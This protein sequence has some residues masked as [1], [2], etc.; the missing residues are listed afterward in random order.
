M[1]LEAALTQAVAEGK[2]LQASLDNINALLGASSNP[3]YRQ[4][5]EELAN[6]GQW[7]ELNDRFF[8]ALKFGTGGLRGRTIGNIVTS[9]E[10][11]GEPE[12]MRPAN[13]CVGTNAMNFFNV[14]RA[15]RGLVQY[16]IDYRK[17]DGVEGK[18]S[19]VFAHDTRHFSKDFAHFAAKI[20][21]DLGVNVYLFESCR[22]TPE[23]SYAVRILRADAGVMITASHNPAHDNGYKVNFN[24]GAGIVEP[25]ATGII[26]QVNAIASETYEALPEAEQGKLTILG[27]DMDEEYLT[28]VQTLMLKPELLEK[29]KG[30]KIVYTALHGTGGV[31]VPKILGKLGFDYVTVP[32]QDIQ[33]GRFPTV[34]SP[35]PENAPTLKMAADLADQVGADAI[36]GTDPDCD[37]MG[38]GVR[39]KEGKLILLTGNQIGSLMAWYRTKTMFELGWLTEANKSHAVLLKTYVTSPMQDTI[40]AKFG[41]NCVNTL[42]GFKW[43]SSKLAKYEAQLGL[44]DKYRDL[45]EAGTRAIRLEKSRFLVFGGEESYGYMGSDF[46][47]DKD[48]NGA[49]VMFAELAAYAAS[50][51]QTVADLLDQVYAEVG[52]FLE[53]NKSKT[54]E[55]AEGAAKIAKLADSYGTNPPTVIDGVQV[56]SVR[57]FRKDV[58]HDEEGERVPAEKMLFVDLAD[59]RSFAV[60]PSGTEPKIKYYMFGRSVPAAGAKFSADELAAAK[61]KAAQALKDLWA[62]LDKDIDARLA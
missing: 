26:K 61:D 40:A 10:R 22:A 41:I 58:I 45:D 11:G 62:W 39:N 18:A 50:Q 43:I 60:R 20:A 33:D 51:G 7:S 57:D 52:Y 21:T 31:L 49:V 14:L 37:R 34:E 12:D 3:L 55:G 27:K 16:C 47:R 9:V 17:A 53:V 1:S 8:Q 59:G 38:V 23:M 15:T 44:G 46:S 2:L 36:I 25:H 6:A 19:I 29:A 54:F 30:L 56:T 13:P 5:I 35:N 4:S 42:T 48:G 24:D 28:R 32:E